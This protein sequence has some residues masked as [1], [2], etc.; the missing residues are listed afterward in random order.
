MP[1]PMA[2]SSNKRI[3]LLTIILL[4][5]ALGLV[6]LANPMAANAAAPI[7]VD[8][9]SSSVPDNIGGR[10]VTC[11]VTVTN[12]LDQATGVTSSVTEVSVCT[13]AANSPLTCTTSTN[14]SVELVNNV[15]QCNYNGNGGGGAINCSVIIINNIIGS[16]TA[17]P[18][19]VNQCV[20][21][22]D[23][24]GADPL[25]CSPAGASTTSATITQCNDSGNNGGGSGRIICNVN[26]LSTVSTSIPVLVNQCNNSANQGGATVICDV[27]I[28]NNIVP[29]STGG[30]GG[31][32]TTVP[33][34]VTGPTTPDSGS[35]PDS[36]GNVPAPN[37]GTG[38]VTPPKSAPAPTLPI[39]GSET[40]K[41]LPLGAL[42]LLIGSILVLRARRT[43]QL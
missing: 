40:I 11:D 32:G 17:T 35:L 19:T 24:G 42:A 8:Q 3:K 34:V 20:G 22:G 23:G 10:G 16:D 14:T 5:S 36:S 25:L 13:G 18:A 12:N 7:T 21:S 38:I 43:A 29:A 33:P 31:T 26:P 1:K 30:T 9:C 2:V 37:A 4:G 6:G 39:T 27:S 41:L 28:T 15:S